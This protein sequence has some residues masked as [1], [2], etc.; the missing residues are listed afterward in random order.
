[1]TTKYTKWPQ[2]TPMAN[3]F[4]NIF[5]WKT[6][7]NLPKLEFLV[8]KYM[9]HLATLLHATQ[10]VSSDTKKSAQPVKILPLFKVS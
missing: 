1:M 10:L 9:Y 6:L 8:W 3:K 4:T 2:Y 5:H 7:Q